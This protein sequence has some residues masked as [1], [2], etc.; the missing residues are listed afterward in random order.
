[1]T[2]LYL[3]DKN[4]I[5][6]A[7]PRT[8]T[9]SSTEEGNK[10]PEREK[11]KV[12]RSLYGDRHVPTELP[13]YDD[14]YYSKCIG[15]GH[16]SQVYQGYY[17]NTLPC[18]IKVLERGDKNLIN[19]EISI[20]QE[21]N[22]EPNIVQLY[23]VKR[24]KT[25]VLIFE[26]IHSTPLIDIFDYI[27]IDQIRKLIFGLLT[28]LEAA[29]K[30]GIVHRDLK[31]ANIMVT[32]DL[33]KIK[34]IDWGC[35]GRIIEGKMLFK[36][37]SRLCRSPEMLLEDQNYGSGC[38]IWAVGILILEILTDHRIP[39]VEKTGSKILVLI[40]KYY[41][42]KQIKDIVKRDK[43]RWPSK[44][45]PKDLYENPAAD[46]LYALSPKKCEL[47]D[48]KLLD[49]MFQ[50]LTVDPALRISATQAL[51]HPFFDKIRSEATLATEEVV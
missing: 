35:G 49:L 36:A 26:L 20:L 40:S 33:S 48:S 24:D 27:T 30:H 38:D 6:M 21:L 5:Y 12:H 22:G 2:N 37:G 47:F 28:A 19:N 45:N 1:M 15:K 11:K 43:L 42:S 8:S 4:K 16:F 10:S 13:Q 3:H 7:D 18:A 25:T 41:G 39:W 51:A 50:L 31:Y 34:L 9:Q 46:L 32:K 29:H 17:R 14:L 44:L 23:D